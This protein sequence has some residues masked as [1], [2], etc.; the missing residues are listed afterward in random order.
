MSCDHQPAHQP[1]W[2]PVQDQIH[3]WRYQFHS[4]HCVDKLALSIYKITLLWLYSIWFRLQVSSKT[5][6]RF[7]WR[8][9]VYICWGCSWTHVWISEVCSSGS[10]LPRHEHFSVKF[11]QEFWIFCFRGMHVCPKRP[12]KGSCCQ[13]SRERMRSSPTSPNVHVTDSGSVQLNISE[14]FSRVWSKRS[15]GVSDV[16]LCHGMLQTLLWVHQS[17][18]WV[19]T[20][21][22]HWVPLWHFHDESDASGFGCSSPTTTS[23]RKN[24]NEFNVPVSI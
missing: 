24:V 20:E 4:L 12:P 19:N 5:E 10:R 18:I 15:S 9:P 2:K 11:F 1:G 21:T 8:P 7:T 17:Y 16:R 6:F 14:F 23:N 22:E 3:S 13:H